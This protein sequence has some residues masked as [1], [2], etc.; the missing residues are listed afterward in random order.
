MALRALQFCMPTQQW[1]RRRGVVLHREFGRLP[2][3]DRMATCAFAVVCA[4]SKLP[5]VRIRLVAV[6][7]LRKRE[8]LLEVTASMALDAANA[9][10]FS[11]QGE[12]GFRVIECLVKLCVRNILP[13]A[14]AVARRTGL[15]ECSAV[16]IAVTIGALAECEARISRLVVRSRM[17]FRA[18]NLR[19]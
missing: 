11:Q 5:V 6:H 1:I 7:A 12:R 8:R 4:L 13:A 2:S 19:M 16:W 15:N 17:A 14:G 3:L 18:R 10:M 9:G